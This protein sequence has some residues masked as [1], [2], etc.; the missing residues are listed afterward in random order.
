MNAIALYMS[1]NKVNVDYTSQFSKGMKVLQAEWRCE[2]STEEFLIQII[3]LNRYLIM[4]YV[5]M[6]LLEVSVAHILRYTSCYFMW[7]SSFHLTLN[8]SHPLS[9]MKDLLHDTITIKCSKSGLLN[10]ANDHIHY[11]ATNFHRNPGFWLQYLTKEQSAVWSED[12][13]LIWIQS[14]L[15]SD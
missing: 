12:H 10:S 6:P 13:K 15:L 1:G 9:S 2:A 4:L 11:L 5:G 7:P 3:I 8:R 14:F